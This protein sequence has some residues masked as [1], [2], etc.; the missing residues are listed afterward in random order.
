M[1]NTKQLTPAERKKA[2]AVAAILKAEREYR[3]SINADPSSPPPLRSATEIALRDADITL[4]M[5]EQFTLTIDGRGPD[6]MRAEIAMKGFSPTMPVVEEDP[7]AEYRASLLEE[8][9]K[10]E[11]AKM[12]PAR[13]DLYFFEKQQREQE[14]D[15]IREA[16]ES[17]EMD[18]R[19]P[20]IDY[21]TSLAETMSVDTNFSDEDV[22]KVY[23]AMEQVNTPGSCHE[24]CLALIDDANRAEIQSNSD[25]RIMLESEMADANKV[26]QEF[27]LDTSPKP[28]PGVE[29]TLTYEEEPYTDAELETSEAFVAAKARRE[30]AK[31]RFEAAANPV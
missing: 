31:R 11:L 16:E 7:A 18:A 15:A 29:S 25:Y 20:W 3:R 27:I 26:L 6:E 19:K 2:K 10:E 1:S 22:Q 21:L 17:K 12:S 30:E 9:E 23:R 14:A 5:S 4:S 24:T 8:I 28:I 13:Q